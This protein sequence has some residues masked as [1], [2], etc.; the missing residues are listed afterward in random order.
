MSVTVKPK[1]CWRRFASSQISSTSLLVLLLTMLPTHVVAAE[2]IRLLVIPYQ[3]DWGSRKIPVKQFT[4]PIAPPPLLL[5]QQ[6]E[7]VESSGFDAEDGINDLDSDWLMD[8]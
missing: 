1:R 8:G 6:V 5:R 3:T 4:A 2:L 7:R